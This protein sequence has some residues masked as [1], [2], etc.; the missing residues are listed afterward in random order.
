[1]KSK[2]ASKPMDILSQESIIKGLKE[3]IAQLAE[4]PIE[5]AKL[6]QPEKGVQSFQLAGSNEIVKYKLA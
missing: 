4:T 2:P 6:I 5:K 3:H 1:M